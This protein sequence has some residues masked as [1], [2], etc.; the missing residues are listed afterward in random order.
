MVLGNA[1]A[2][3]FVE[4]TP[5]VM[6]G[7]SS[8]SDRNLI[9]GN[10]TSGIIIRDPLSTGNRVLGNRIGT[11]ENGTQAVPNGQNGVFL[12][13]APGNFIGGTASGEGNLISGNGF[14][15][16]SISQD[17]A[18]GNRIR[19]NH[20][21]TQ[22][23]GTSPLATDTTASQPGEATGNGRW[24]VV[25]LGG[26]HDNSVGGD[27]EPAG[28]R[29]AFN[30]RDGVQISSGTGNTIRFNRIFDNQGLGIDL[31]QDE[32]VTPNDPPAGTE[33]P[34]DPPAD[35]DDGANRLQNFPVL[36]RVQDGSQVEVSLLSTPGQSFTIDLYGNDSCDPSGNG[37][38]QQ[39]LGILQITTNAQGVF[40]CGVG[41]CLFPVP[42]DKDIT[43]TATGASGSTSEFSFCGVEEIVVN[44][45]ED[46]PLKQDITTCTTGDQAFKAR[47]GEDECTLRA[48][49]E[50][51]NK[52]PGRDRIEFDIKEG[53]APYT[54]QPSQALPEVSTPMSIDG[55]TQSGFVEGLFPIVELTGIDAGLGTSGLVVTGGSTDIKG[56]VINAFRGNGVVLRSQG[57][58]R[59]DLN[60][61]GTTQNGQDVLPNTGYGVFIDNTSENLIGLP[62]EG[63]LPRNVISGNVSDGVR[64]EGRNASLNEIKG[65]YVGLGA[66]G[67]KSIGNN[68]SGINVIDGAFSNLI[69]G[70]VVS[71]NQLTGVRLTGCAADECEELNN[72]TFITR[73][74]QVFVNLVGTNAIGSQ[75]L[76]NAA[77]VAIFNSAD[78]TIGG[79]GR[80]NVVSGN[81]GPGIFVFGLNADRNIIQ[82]NYVGID[83]DGGCP[84]FADLGQCTLANSTRPIF[85]PA[86][87]N[88]DPVV[89]GG[90][91]V[92]Q[93]SETQIGGSDPGLG[94]LIAGNGGDGIKLD[95]AFTTRVQGN[96]IGTDITGKI[97]IAN[98]GNGVRV[99][100]SSNVTIGGPDRSVAACD[101][102]CNLISGN[103]FN[104]VLIERGQPVQIQ[105]NFIG[106]DIEGEED[107][108]NLKSGIFVTHLVLS[109]SGEQ[110]EHTIGGQQPQSGNLIS[111]NDVDG[112][113]IE[114]VSSA[115]IAQNHIHHNLIGTNADATRRVPNL[116]FGISI[117]GSQR[118]IVGSP[119]AG[120][121]I[122]GN[123]A[124]G[125]LITL[126]E[127]GGPGGNNT[128]QSNYVGTNAS[129]AD[130]PNL[131]PGIAINTP[132]N[133][134]GGDRED[135]GNLV[136]FN[137]DE[138]VL[139][140]KEDRNLIFHN[141]L[142]DN[143]RL[144]INL[145]GGNENM[146]YPLLESATSGNTLIRGRF[147]FPLI[148]A[149]TLQ[150][151]SNPTCHQS[152]NGEGRHILG[153]VNLPAGRPD[154]RIRPPIPVAAGHV[155]TAT[156][157]D[158][159]GNTSEFSNC[160][161]DPSPQSCARTGLTRS[162]VRHSRKRSVYAQPDRERLLGGIAGA[163][164]WRRSSYNLHWFDTAPG[165]NQSHGSPASRASAGH[166][167][168]SPARRWIFVPLGFHD[169][170]CPKSGS[171][172][173]RTGS[174]VRH[175]R[176]RSFY[177]RP[178]RK[179]FH[180]RVPGAMERRRTSYNLDQS[181]STPGG[182]Q[183]C[184]C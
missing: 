174:R 52:R 125:I 59:L 82:G 72:P 31:G 117:I 158:D 93:A 182:D 86:P 157:T 18:S 175:N 138:G 162:R 64:I 108:G 15:A 155:V 156:A 137:L 40:D 94:N 42:P 132:G 142:F 113:R 5:D 24:G 133:E 54:I 26:A 7:G 164:G 80:R 83:P 44:S 53:S 180:E 171:C 170:S 115:N 103:L 33:P 146:Y 84:E 151:F 102:S 109:G 99:T 96:R 106:T 19:G 9:S 177:T 148:P 116:D 62:E 55:T 114:K 120:N 90:I 123:G 149:T 51:A 100:D 143:D 27:S 92:L 39:H 58:N 119:G 140:A 14:S 70:N 57:G 105:G 76:P 130:L 11:N 107:R 122:A 60:Y 46:D 97:A 88:E 141:R 79:P 3:I 134:V 71:G 167:F 56:L 2:G 87:F 65:N 135:E 13:D 95:F 69:L 74:N 41:A 184:G 1:F 128:I 91:Y 104:G 10:G 22:Q 165:G 28:N 8:E 61:I 178:V 183:R 160:G 50:L 47:T 163:L 136:A 36:T 12:F 73:K 152:G 63:E 153:H 66:F 121:V 101:G 124:G 181:D 161:A 168:Q 81:G 89:A 169:R 179:R 29:I 127:Q 110:G 16:V 159:F 23:D 67:S 126:G 118:N 45:V 21:G 154:F 111:G 129:E 32:Q 78:N 144:G 37:E 150:F 176:K 145:E 48:A 166:C 30:G 6:I 112:I 43:A 68:G 98:L 35:S 38:G 139:V 172:V 20:I 4:Q 147:P 34:F 131:G 25:I 75:P 85:A 77:G 49:I 173:E 17:D